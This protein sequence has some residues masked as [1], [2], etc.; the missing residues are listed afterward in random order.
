MNRSRH[1]SGQG[2]RRQIFL[3]ILFVNFII[4]FGNYKQGVAY[5]KSTGKIDRI[6]F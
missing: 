4:G 5:A 2:K 6:F 1:L 3:S